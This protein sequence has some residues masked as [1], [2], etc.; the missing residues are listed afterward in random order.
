MRCQRKVHHSQQT[1]LMKL[2]IIMQ[3]YMSMRNQESQ[4][5]WMIAVQSALQTQIH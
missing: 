5:Q 4:A 3:N 1:N 2:Q